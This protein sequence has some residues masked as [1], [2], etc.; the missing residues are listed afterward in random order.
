MQ[1]EKSLINSGGQHMQFSNLASIMREFNIS[2]NDPK[3]IRKVLSQ[4]RAEIHPDKTGGNF[5]SKEVSNRFYEI[6]NAI[7]YIEQILTNSKSDNIPV[8]MQDLTELIKVIRDLV[9][10]QNKIDIAEEKLDTSIKNSIDQIK[11]RFRTP[12]IAI[13][14]ITTIISFIWIFPNTIKEH[15]VLGKVID[16][17]SSN[18]TY[19]WLEII[20][21]C[22]AIWLFAFLNETR[23][24]EI[25]ENLGVESYQNNLFDEFVYKERI[26]SNI[27]KEEFIE[28]LLSQF[29][30]KSFRILPNFMRRGY[31]DRQLAQDIADLIMSRAEKRGVI[32][33]ISGK[34]LSNL[35]T[36]EEEYLTHLFGKF[37]IK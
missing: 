21:F 1:L 17:T 16:I 6:S 15:P 9:P 19:I 23:E 2:E 37:Y 30:N 33:Q 27:T 22:V 34:S 26:Q 25:K 29:S 24:K 11:L 3:E 28:F 18:F 4:M 20:L 12:K 14:T 35:Y 32:T 13:S 5:L 10:P 8:P 7:E 31:I 36:V